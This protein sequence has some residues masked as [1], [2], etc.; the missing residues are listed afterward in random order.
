ML[1]AAENE[2]RHRQNEHQQA[3]GLFV[4]AHGQ[5]HH[6]AAAKA[7][8]QRLQRGLGELC[9]HAAAGKAKIP[10]RDPSHCHSAQQIAQKHQGIISDMTAKMVP[11]QREIPD[12]AGVERR[13]GEHH[14]D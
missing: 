4:A 10:R 13:T 11:F 6:H 7:Q 8:G 14:P 5:I 2:H 1:K 12:A 3:A 9:L